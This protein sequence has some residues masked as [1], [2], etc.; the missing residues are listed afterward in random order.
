MVESKSV[1]RRKKIQMMG[2]IAELKAKLA[3][4]QKARAVLEEALDGA[5]EDRDY[6]SD[7]LDDMESW[8]DPMIC[9]HPT[10]ALEH[11]EE[12]TGYCAWCEDIARIKEQR[13][14]LLAAC[15]AVQPMLYGMLIE[16][17]G[18]PDNWP[19]GA[20]GAVVYQKLK[21]AITKTKP[22]S[23]SGETRE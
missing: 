3:E 2:T 16:R 21:T 5:L 17:W 12:G 11:D 13:D 19:E 4:C 10:W 9:G 8:D 15:E 1:L 14:N 6:F 22:V 7:R 23:P 18:H 20:Q